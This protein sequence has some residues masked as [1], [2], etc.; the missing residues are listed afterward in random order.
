MLVLLDD[1]TLYAVEI[2]TRFEIQNIYKI[3]SNC[4]SFAVIN[5]FLY[6]ISGSAVYRIDFAP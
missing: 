6:Y 1:F 4:S 5:E 2:D 3:T